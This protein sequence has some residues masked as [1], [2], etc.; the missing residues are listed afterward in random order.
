M[1]QIIDCDNYTRSK[2]TKKRCAY[3]HNEVAKYSTLVCEDYVNSKC[4]NV[5][6][7]LRHP[8]KK[9][10]NIEKDYVGAGILPYAFINNDLHILVGYQQRGFSDFGGKKDENDLCIADTCIR[11]FYEETI[12]LFADK[13]VMEL[14]DIRKGVYNPRYKYC[15][16]LYEVSHVSEEKFAEQKRQDQ[17]SRHNRVADA[18][19]TDIRWAHFK[20]LLEFYQ[21][22]DYSTPFNG[23]MFYPA[24]LES[25]VAAK[26]VLL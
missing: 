7:I 26:V 8:S 23:I 6:C 18:E 2:C 24:A 20:S 19:K 3:R 5:T 11:E 10:F 13:D 16:L 14:L 4:Q 9:S 17:R 15:M 12:G 1:Q 21:H 25:I 22:N